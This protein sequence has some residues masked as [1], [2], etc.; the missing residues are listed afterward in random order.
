MFRPA[1][2]QAHW[3]ELSRFPG[4][5]NNIANACFPETLEFLSYAKIIE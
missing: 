2:K 5:I 1:L 3:S 4:W